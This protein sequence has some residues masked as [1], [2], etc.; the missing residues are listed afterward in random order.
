LRDYTT[1]LSKQL[2]DAL[3]I[4]I[5]D[6]LTAAWN[7]LGKPKKTVDEVASS[8][9]LDPEVLQHWVDY[10]PKEHTFPY[11]N[12]WKAMTASTEST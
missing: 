11:L 8:K 10:L 3:S 2:A 4:Q 7:V 1:A 5:S 6:Y 9:Q 12:D